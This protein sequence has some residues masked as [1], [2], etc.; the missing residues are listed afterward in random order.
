[1]K[2]DVLSDLHG[3]MPQLPGGDLLILCG[4]YTAAGRTLQWANFFAWL[5]DQDYQKKI[6][7]GGNHDNFLFTSFPKTRQEAEDL[8]DVREMLTEVEL[9]GVNDFEYLCDSGTEFGGLKIWGVPWT[10]TFDGINP[11]CTAFTLQ[12]EGEMRDKLKLV[13]D[14]VDILV[15]HSTPYG[16]LDKNEDGK[17]CGS[18]AV[19][20]ALDRVKPLYMFF[21]HIHEEGGKQVLYK[22]IGPNTWCCN[23]SHVDERYKVKNKALT[24]NKGNDGIQSSPYPSP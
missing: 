24:I 16:I 18:I 17:S 13:P 10:L 1:M 20:E 4:D 9:E 7:I 19:L 14:D 2:I 21:G 6:I 5:K 22:H 12:H 15:C 11:H 3:Y 8:A 23:V